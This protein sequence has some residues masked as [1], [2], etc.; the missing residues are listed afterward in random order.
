MRVR[1]RDGVRRSEEG[2]NYDEVD[3]YSRKDRA[4]EWAQR[5]DMPLGNTCYQSLSQNKMYSV[6]EW[7]SGMEEDMDSF[8]YC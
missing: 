8:W 6:R 3:G 5:W 2:R 7:L 1:G 4:A